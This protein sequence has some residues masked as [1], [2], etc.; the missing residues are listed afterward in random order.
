VLAH[1]ALEKNNKLVDT[2][3]LVLIDRIDKKG[4]CIGRNEGYK[5]VSIEK[6][7]K[8]YVGEFVE[9][10]IVECTPWALKGKVIS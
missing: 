2:K 3:Q 4:R 9:V 1:T 5:Q 8:K 7:E 10:E 6:G